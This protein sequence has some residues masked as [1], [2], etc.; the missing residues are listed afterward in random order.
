[1]SGPFSQFTAPLEHLLDTIENA[2]SGALQALLVQL[3][4]GGMAEQVRSWVGHG[5]N[6]PVTPEEL[7]L[8]FTPEQIDELALR[9]GTSPDVLLAQLAND[10]P[11][12][13]H[14][15]TPDGKVPPRLI[16]D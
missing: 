9:T 16:D 7:G 5:P 15:A 11:D 14:R 10:L 1:M 4:A 3:E 6:A 13:V 8:A 12:A 2:G